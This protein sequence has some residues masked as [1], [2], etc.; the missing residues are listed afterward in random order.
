MAEEDH[1][2]PGAHAAPAPGPAPKRRSR[3]R[4]AI[5]DSPLAFIGTVGVVIF[6]FLTLFGP[7]FAP[8]SYDQIIR[9]TGIGGESRRALTSQA[10]S[11]D[12]LMGTDQRGRDIYSRMLWGARET[13]GLPLVATL[14]SLVIGSSLGLLLGYLGGVVDDVVS[15]LLDTL[16]SIPALVLALVMISTIVPM[17]R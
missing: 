8:Y 11:A 12:F 10:P 6:V 3:L 17:L 7:L 9:G 4:T 13:I 5:T 15:R 2:E 16:M 14:A 1:S